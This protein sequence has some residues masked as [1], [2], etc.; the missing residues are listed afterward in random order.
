[1]AGGQRGAA[2]RTTLAGTPQVVLRVVD[3]HALLG[4]GKE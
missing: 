3:T 4:A 2:S 1:M